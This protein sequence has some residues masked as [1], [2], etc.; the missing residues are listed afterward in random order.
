MRKF[1]AGLSGT[2]Q[3]QIV[4][5]E[6]QQPQQIEESYCFPEGD[7]LASKRLSLSLASSLGDPRIQACA[8]LPHPQLDDR[9]LQ[10][11]TFRDCR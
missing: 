2:I 9:L 1:L 3:E 5:E 6:W 8:I 11:P 10:A 7:N 4:D